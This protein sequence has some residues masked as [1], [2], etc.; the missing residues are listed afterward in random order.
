[1]DRIALTM[2]PLRP[3]QPGFLPALVAALEGEGKE[4]RLAAGAGAADSAVAAPG[5]GDL[6]RW[7]DLVVVIGGDGSILRAVHQMFPVLRPVMGVNS[8]RLGFLSYS[9]DDAPAEIARAIRQRDYTISERALL[10]AVVIRHGEEVNRVTAL[11]EITVTR[12]KVAR[13]IH[14]QATVQG[15]LLNDYHADGLI[16]AT[17][18]GSTAYSMSAGGPVVAPDAGVL[19]LTPICPHALSNRSVVVGDTEAIELRARPAD[20]GD[21]LMFTA[22]G[23]TACLLEPGDVLRLQ[24][25]AAKLPLVVRAEGSFFETLRVKLRW[26]GSNV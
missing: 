1:M 22:D 18:T 19:V 21:A 3:P 13:M 7:A 24:R 26:H 12:R 14:V 11:N 2:N 5:L 20:D 15:H 16:V 4:V 8:G 6:V 17:P 25:A 23:E 10:D 9:A